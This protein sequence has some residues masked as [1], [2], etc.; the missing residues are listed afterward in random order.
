MGKGTDMARELG[1]GL[2]A[3]AMDDFKDQ[4]LIVFL[5]RLGGKVSIPV[6]EMDDT[7]QDNLTLSV[8]DG[9]FHMETRKK[10]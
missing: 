2:H 3:D 4:L 9:V 10:S 7:G 8:V 6:T 1:G 5:K